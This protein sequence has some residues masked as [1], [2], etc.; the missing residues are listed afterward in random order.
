MRIPPSI[1]MT[2]ASVAALSASAAMAAEIT[3][4][5]I[6]VMAPGHPVLL[7]YA[8]AFEN[9]ATAIRCGEVS[10]S[11]AAGQAACV[12]RLTAM[13]IEKLRSV[14]ARAPEGG[15]SAPVSLPSGVA[16]TLTRDRNGAPGVAAYDAGGTPVALGSTAEKVDFAKDRHAVSDDVVL[17]GDDRVAWLRLQGD[18]NGAA[19]AATAALGVNAGVNAGGSGL[20]G[21][22][23]AG[24]SGGGVSV[25]AG[26]TAG[27]VDASASVSAGSGGVSAGVGAT[28]GGIDASA[29]VSAGS[30]GVSA[31]AG[32]TAGGV[33]ADAGVSA[34][35]GGISAGGGL[36][37]GDVDVG[38]SV[39]G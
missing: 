26:A 2:I 19:T 33:D 31:G 24:V 8:V 9:G 35:S 18:P 29:G 15:A 1:R 28:A 20:G 37:A 4:G 11:V 13:D 3:T 5:R 36:G 23:T 7:P 34:G 21:G 30:G 12:H 38:V 16:M 22:V 17:T 14:A 25:G 27:G 6:D 39:G 32:A 10:I